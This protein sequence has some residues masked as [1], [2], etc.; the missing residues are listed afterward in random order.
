MI[1]RDELKNILSKKVLFLDGAVGTELIKGGFSEF[2]Q[3]IFLLRNQKAI[4]EIQKEYVKAG[5]DILLTATLGANPLKLKTIG[6]EERMEELNERAV[7]IAQ[8]AATSNVLVAG[9]L[10]PTGEFFPSSG[11]LSFA[12]VYDCFSEE[13]KVFKKKG[14]DLFILETFS[15]IRE[16]KAACFAVRDNAPDSFI[17]ANLTFDKNGR[18]LIG[19]DPTGFALAFED[20]DVDALGINCSLG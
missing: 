14:V 9:N 16:L 5:C 10:G 12:K 6:L 20:L 15:D 17:I 13:V 7:A 18:T 8:N 11:T 19:T 1:K 2:S 4:L 3:E